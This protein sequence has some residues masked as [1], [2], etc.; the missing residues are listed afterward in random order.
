MFDAR[1][2]TFKGFRSEVDKHLRNEDRG[3][4]VSKVKLIERIA[5]S[6]GMILMVGIMLVGPGGVV[7]GLEYPFGAGEY[8]DNGQF[9]NRVQAVAKDLNHW[10]DTT[11]YASRVQGELEGDA[12]AAPNSRARAV[13]SRVSSD[14]TNML[15]ATALGDSGSFDAALLQF[16]SDAKTMNSWYSDTCKSAAMTIPRGL[17]N[18]WS[19]FFGGWN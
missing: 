3:C 4:N 17:N 12:S 14:M 16:Q 9:C 2:G 15:T 11:A 10:Q 18:I 5:T 19:G 6:I 13:F 8:S 7:A 1:G